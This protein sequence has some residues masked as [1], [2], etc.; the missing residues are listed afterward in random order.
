MRT[1]PRCSVGP[2]VMFSGRH[3]RSED[4]CMASPREHR[5]DMSITSANTRPLREGFSPPQAATATA[6]LMS[7]PPPI[8]VLC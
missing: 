2:P 1:T 8:G 6:V 5:I 7:F 4:F 3:S